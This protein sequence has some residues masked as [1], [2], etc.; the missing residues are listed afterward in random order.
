MQVGEVKVADPAGVRRQLERHRPG[1]ELRLT[2][3]RG[4]RSL[5]LAVKVGSSPVEE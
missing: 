3:S 5:V 2:V 4:E 1:D